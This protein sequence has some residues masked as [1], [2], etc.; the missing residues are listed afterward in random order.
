MLGAGMR[1]FAPVLA[2]YGS[3]SPAASMKS[4]VRSSSRISL[5]LLAIVSLSAMTAGCRD[6]VTG[7]AAAARA[8]EWATITAEKRALDVARTALREERARLRSAPVR[9]DGTLA[10][11]ASASLQKD[12]DARERAV[13]SASRALEERLQRFATGFTVRAGEA[14]P[15]ALVAAVHL[16]SDE[17]IAIAQEWIERG[18]DYRH[19]LAIYEAQQ[20]IDPA[21]APLAEAIAHA[22]DMRAVT[23]ARCA[24]V[25][26]GMSAVEVR[27]LLGPVNV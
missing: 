21:Y 19:A 22:R 17:D 14:P 25:R 5:A 3:A 11:E 7:R 20:R 23:P 16:K 9:A 24:Q 26:P 6:G 12:V 15:P 4:L 18:G 1:P 2:C 10:D 13:A 27:A 8:R